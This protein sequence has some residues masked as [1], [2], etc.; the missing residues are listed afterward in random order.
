VVYELLTGRFPFDTSSVT[1]LI[2][3]IQTQESDLDH[4]LLPETEEIRSSFL[5]AAHLSGA[6]PN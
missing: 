2:T 4:P 3:Q 5:L 6:R 1:N